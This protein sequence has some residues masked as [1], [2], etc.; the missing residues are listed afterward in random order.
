MSERIDMIFGLYEKPVPRA[1]AQ[2][3]VSGGGWFSI[4][5]VVLRDVTI[6]RFGFSIPCTEAVERLVKL[7]PLL[8]VGSGSGY[9]AKILRDAGADIIA[10]DLG[11]ATD[12]FQT[13]AGADVQKMSADD[14]VLK[15]PDR[16]VF[17]SWPSY[18]ESWAG[19]MAAKIRPGKMLAYIG[20]G[21][22]G[23]TADAGFF[24]L[25]RDGFEEVDSVAIPKWECIH[26]YLEI[27][28]RK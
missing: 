12:F 10:T 1:V 19:E 27:Y 15:W 4:E 22:C 14:A 8:E 20:E 17:V 18:D 11:E 21:R 26:D 7:S 28:R 24:D 9:W 16:N 25:L 6:K 3:I 23:C 2:K 5:D 13:W